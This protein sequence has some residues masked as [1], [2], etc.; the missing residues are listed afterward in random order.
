[1][2]GL[3]RRP[4]RLSIVTFLSL[5]LGTL[6]GVPMAAVMY[7]GFGTAAETAT[8]LIDTRSSMIRAQLVGRTRNFLSPAEQVPTF[9]G[10]VIDAG[11]IDPDD[12]RAIGEAIRYAAAAAAQLS[13]IGYASADGWVEHVSAAPDGVPEVLDDDWREDPVTR[14]AMN[15]AAGQ[16]AKPHWMPPLF[17][18]ELDQTVLSYVRPILRDGTFRGATFA[19][20]RKGTLDAFLKEMAQSIGAT[21][22]LLA[23]RQY[24]L[25][26]SSGTGPFKATALRPLPVLDEVGDPVLA[27][28]WREDAW[29]RPLPE[30]PA[31][32]GWC[33]STDATM[34]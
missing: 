21:V 1:M 12:K 28:M 6:V 16:G 24:V 11:A 7:L 13:T 23:D 17:I 8:T 32:A 20:V 33:A 4:W 26:S 19:S 2:R 34:R 10:R 18:D 27:S 5:L 14:A 3:K 29:V 9:L 25:A 22:Y 30:G 15:E 31:K